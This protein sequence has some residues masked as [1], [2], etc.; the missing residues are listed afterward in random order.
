MALDEALLRYAGRSGVCVLRFYEWDRPSISIGYLQDY[1]AGEREGFAVV[2]RPTGGGVVFHDHDL[3]YTVAIPAEHWICG[4][5]REASYGHINHAVTSGLNQC[6][7]DAGLTDATI[8]HSVARR[9][10]ICF[11]N[12]TRYD[13]VLG[14]KKVAGAAQRRVR[15]GI[16]HQGSI[17]FGGPL[18]VSRH[19]LIDEIAAGFRRELDVELTEFEPSAELFEEADKIAADKYATDRWNRKR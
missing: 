14:G 7:L 11:E 3:T 18:P 17:H 15:E 8:P 10:M 4:V 6:N 13:I 16:L 19:V 5:D 9:T 1:A 2:R 12:P